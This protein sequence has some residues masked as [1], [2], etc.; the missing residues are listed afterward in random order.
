MASRECPKHRNDSWPHG[1]AK[2]PHFCPYRR[3][4]NDDSET[5]CDCCERCEDECRDDI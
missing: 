2:E 5:L 3:E 1:P 4:I